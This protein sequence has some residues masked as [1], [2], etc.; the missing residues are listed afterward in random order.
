[1]GREDGYNAGSVLMAFVLGGAVGAG[2]AL[3]LA[4]QSGVETR[5]RIREF[6]DEAKGKASEYACTAKETVTSTVDRAKD[7]YEEKKSAI[8]AAVEAGKQAYPQEVSTE[9]LQKEIGR[10]D[11]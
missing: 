7:L 4:P 11:A 9:T 8:T 3:L 2:I 10:N 6:A 1:M 5:R